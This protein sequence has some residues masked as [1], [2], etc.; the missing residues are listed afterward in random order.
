MN[1][2]IVTQAIYDSKQ[3]KRIQHQIQSVDSSSKIYLLFEEEISTRKSPLDIIPGLQFA[4]QVKAHIR[5][6]NSQVMQPD[7]FSEFE[8]LREKDPVTAEMIKPGWLNSSFKSTRLG[9][10]D[11][12]SL[13]F[14]NTINNDLRESL[15]HADKRF[16]P[17]DNQSY[18]GSADEFRMY[19][20]SVPGS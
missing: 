17:S 8:Q 3:A 4:P 15:Y 16:R 1:I 12:D 18:A 19:V 13:V 9:L 7:Y 6:Y 2:G 5:E 20:G 11:L 10:K 14:D